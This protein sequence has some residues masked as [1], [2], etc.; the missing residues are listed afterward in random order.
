MPVTR[1][2]RSRAAPGQ[3]CANVENNRRKK[4]LP[5]QLCR[6][7]TNVGIGSPKR[8]RKKHSFESLEFDDAAF[9]PDHGGV[10]SVVR[11]QLGEDVL[12]SSLDGFLRNSEL[13]RN[14]FV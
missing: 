8:S 4:D 6:V 3:P 1:R 10:G 5:L 14:L 12:H 13:M 9:D 7:G 2:K 11:A